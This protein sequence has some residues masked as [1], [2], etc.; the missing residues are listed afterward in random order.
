MSV[1]QKQIAQHLGISR[2]LVGSA[3]NDNSTVPAVTRRRVLEA[4]RELGYN[5]DANRDARALIGRRYGHRSRT[6][7]VGALFS[8]GT[9]DHFVC[10]ST[11]QGL[12]RAA[13]SLDHDVLVLAR[14]VVD[15]LNLADSLLQDGRCDGYIFVNYVGIR[16]T[17]EAL[18]AAGIPAV[19]CL[20]TDNPAGV[21]W[22]VP[23]NEGAM[24]LAVEHLKS[25]GHRRIA[26]LTGSLDHSDAA[27]RREG[28][29]RAM[30]DVG[31]S[32]HADCISL[33][34]WRTEPPTPEVLR[35]LELDVTAIVCANDHLALHLWEQAERLGKRVP[36]DLSIIGVDNE[37]LAVERGLTTITNPFP[38]IGA[39]A[40]ES[41][42]ARE[43]G[44]PW[45]TAC[46]K[47]PVHLVARRSV[48]EPRD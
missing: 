18:T 46:R 10:A 15:G 1:T 32:D 37:P 25:L 11:F 27:Q 26:H 42:L 4:A 21:P 35:A 5:G 33:G 14:D 28:F 24:R 30:M 19:T 44:E 34:H 17:L 41:L 3:L 23:D 6:R 9:T 13:R 45:E 47:V 8:A 29:R 40:M 39:A 22:I 48:G 12:H 7:V 43:R 16:S 36:Q 20:S 2:S 38:E 31:L